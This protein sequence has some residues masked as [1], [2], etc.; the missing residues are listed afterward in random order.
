MEKHG[1][2]PKFPAWSSVFQVF[3]PVWQLNL[4]HWVNLRRAYAYAVGDV[5]VCIH[6]F[7][8]WSL[9]CSAVMSETEL[10]VLNLDLINLEQSV[11]FFQGRGKNSEL[12]PYTTARAM[13]IRK[14]EYACSSTAIALAMWASYLQ[15]QP[16]TF[17][18]SLCA[19]QYTVL[20]WHII[21]NTLISAVKICYTVNQCNVSRTRHIRLPCMLQ[22]RLQCFSCTLLWL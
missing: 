9:H 22:C 11:T 19:N 4:W 7:A 5:V 6:A 1:D 18:Y 21:I 13:K 3:S 17:C 8:L 15:L 12:S 14:S 2:S 10:I 16:I 20:T